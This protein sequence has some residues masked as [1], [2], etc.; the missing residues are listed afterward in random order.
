MEIKRDFIPQGHYNRPGY[1]MNPTYITIHTTRN[2]SKGAD[3][4]MHARFIKNPTTAQSWHYSC[5]DK[6]IYQHL[7]TTENGWHAGDGG[8]GTG[9]RKSIGI[10]ICENSDGDF[11][12][13]VENA[14][15]LT[16][17]L[18]D[19]HNIPMN[20]VVPHNHWSGKN[21]PAPLLSKFGDFKEMV[22]GKKKEAPKQ[23]T[24]SHQIE[25]DYKR[26]STA[27]RGKRVES[28]YKGS[29]GLN[30]YSRPTWK[31]PVGTFAY[32]MG[33]TI[34]EKISV[35]GAY[36]YKVKNSKGDVYYITAAPEYVKVINTKPAYIGKRVEA[37]VSKVNFYDSPR[38]NRPTGQFY[39]GQGWTIVGKLTTNGSPQYQVKNSKGD[40]YYITARKDLVKVIY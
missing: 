20:R 6:Q 5:D 29:E 21:C 39:K 9:N 14:A 28:I 25:S 27:D 31:S 4:Y 32:G 30:F 12:K 35:D 34:V 11:Q 36:Q 37:I 24:A 1:S 16:K 15:W 2:L 3:A 7:P 18:M 10:E 38:W 33:W 26:V 22:E 40:I 19:E 13:A 23:Q 17:K 8:N